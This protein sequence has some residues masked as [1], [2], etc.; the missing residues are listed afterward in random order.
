[1][2]DITIPTFA[3]TSALQ[4]G[5]TTK[6]D[7]SDASAY[8]TEN[9]SDYYVNMLIYYAKSDGSLSVVVTPD[10]P[11]PNLATLWTNSISSDGI[12]TAYATFCLAYGQEAVTGTFAKGATTYYNNKF[13]LAT[14]N[15]TGSTDPSSG[16]GNDAAFVELTD[17]LPY[18]SYILYTPSSSFLADE[19][20]KACEHTERKK[21]VAK[22]KEGCSCEDE[23]T[24]NKLWNLRQAAQTEF[25]L[26]NLLEA[27]QNIELAIAICENC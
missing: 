21:A 8:A 15:I 17:I 9:A 6:I 22:Y 18:I 26:S 10:N 13:Y 16:T 3:I 27:Q 20:I 4:S 12:Y 7:H 11:T 25:S 5:D 19:S 24:L 14:E 1:M 23:E 2:P